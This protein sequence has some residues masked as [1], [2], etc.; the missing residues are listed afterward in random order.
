[1]HDMVRP[2]RDMLA[3]MPDGDTG[4]VALALREARLRRA[5]V[6]L[7]AVGPG[8]RALDAEGCASLGQ[9]LRVNVRASDA[10]CSLGAAGYA[11]V[12]VGAGPSGAERAAARLVRVLGTPV[13]VIALD[14]GETPEAALVRLG[15]P[16]APPT[17]SAPLALPTRRCAATP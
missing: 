5:P 14:A 1:M 4:A 6:A 3:D 9:R 12:L 2:M 17:T 16:L 10:V 13:A 11:T 8:E 15:A 7:L